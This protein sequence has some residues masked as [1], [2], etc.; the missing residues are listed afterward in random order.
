MPRPKA[1]RC[2][3]RT[4][5]GRFREVR[6]GLGFPSGKDKTI[7]VDLTG[8]FG[9]TGPRRLRL[10]TNLEI[11][12]DTTAVG[13]RPARTSRCAHAGSN[14]WRAD[15]AYRGYSVTEQPDPKRSGAPALRAGG[16]GSAV[17]RSRG[18]LHALRRRARICCA[19]VDD[20]YVIMN[21]GDELRLRFPEAPPPARGLVR[22]F[23]VIG[24][25]WVKDGDYNT[26][27]SRTVLPLPTHRTGRYD[28]PPRQ[29]EDDPVYRRHAARL[30]RVPYPV[31][32]P[33]HPARRAL[34]RPPR[35]HPGNRNDALRPRRARRHLRR[36]A[37]DAV[38]DPPVR[39]AGQRARLGRRGEPG[40]AVRLPPDRIGEGRGAR[41]SCTSAPT[42]DPKLAHIMPQVASMGAAVSVV[43]V[44]RD[45]L[46]D[47]YV[48]DSKEG[49]GE[50]A[51]PQPRQRHVR[52]RGGAARRRRPQPR[53]GR[54]V[55]GRRLGRLRQ[56]RLRRSVP[57]SLGTP[58]ALSQRSR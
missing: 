6:K 56:R 43:D 14:C 50:P 11:F 42:L 58:R 37:A 41:R 45:G 8:L 13:R 51:V 17:A 31:R 29:L 47:L 15:L 32:D 39:S 33:R 9:A 10:A 3:W 5:A 19:A 7:L 1:C 21:A 30:R 38:P 22:D 53:G 34:P 57:L 55:D 16:N 35:R 54:R 2:T 18:L 44:D 26:S 24:D 20:R 46:P 12:W 52:R 4:P 36:A 40:D 28:V 48:T 23:I 27:F 49:I 25:G